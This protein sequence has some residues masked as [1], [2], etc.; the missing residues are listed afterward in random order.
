M[1]D[2]SLRWSVTLSG[3]LLVSYVWRLLMRFSLIFS[4]KLESKYQGQKLCRFFLFIY[5]LSWYFN[6]CRLT[7]GRKEG[8]RGSKFDHQIGRKEREREKKKEIICSLPWS[9]SQGMKV[10]LFF[11]QS[12]WLLYDTFG[13]PSL[14][15]FFFSF[16][17]S[18]FF[19]LF[20]FFPSPHHP[21]K[22][23]SGQRTSNFIPDHHFCSSVSL[24]TLLPSELLEKVDRTLERERNH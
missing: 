13:L 4:S 11:F 21:I 22:N 14:S 7:R 17:F 23:W 15:L 20:S 9:S 10:L 18:L 8:K 5:R 19:F 2:E 16:S 24:P 1:S 12:L 3:Y 6:Y